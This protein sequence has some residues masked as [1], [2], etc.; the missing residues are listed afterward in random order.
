MFFGGVGE[1]GKNMT[2]LE[3]GDNILV[4]DAGMGKVLEIV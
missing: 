2:A 1:I 3:Y 4:V